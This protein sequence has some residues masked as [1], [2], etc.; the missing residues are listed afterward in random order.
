M[1]HPK[2]Y[3]R[4]GTATTRRAHGVVPVECDNPYHVV[5]F[6]AVTSWAGQPT[7]R[8]D[9]NWH[10]YMDRD[11]EMRLFGPLVGRESPQFEAGLKRRAL[12]AF[13][14]SLKEVSE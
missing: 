14:K 2:R 8:Q 7:P 12:A 6:E 5:C 1:Q 11:N 3:M 10:I 9:N 4:D 13:R